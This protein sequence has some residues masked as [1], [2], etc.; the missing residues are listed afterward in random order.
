MEKLDIDKKATALIV[1]DLQKGIVSRNTVPHDT[2]TVVANA[3]KLAGA[4]RARAPL[5]A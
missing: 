5:C 4:F 3:A 2:K 1:I